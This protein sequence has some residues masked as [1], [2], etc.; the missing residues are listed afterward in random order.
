MRDSGTN[1]RLSD[2][3]PVIYRADYYPF[4]PN[5]RVSPRRS[6]VHT[7]LYI[8]NGTGTITIGQNHYSCAG[9]ELF[10]IPPGVSHT[11]HANPSDPM[12]HASVYFDWTG[13]RSHPGDMSLFSFKGDELSQS[14]CST[15]IIF[16]GGPQLPAKVHAPHYTRWM[17]SFLYIID[18]MDQQDEETLLDRRASFELFAAGLAQ[19]IRQPLPVR[20]QR[21][22]KIMAQMENSPMSNLSVREWADQVGVSTSFLHRLFVQVTGM[23]PHAYALQCKLE[24]ARKRIRE[25]ND[26]IS[27]VAEELGFGS[28]HYFSRL[29]RARFGESPTAYRHRIRNRY[30]QD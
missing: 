16:Q 15:S 20:D 14:E 27:A 18:T 19:A 25:T 8:V 23:G 11:F 5:E 4:H 10:Y 29:F 3:C 30:I 24:R 9:D 22:L 21:V 17:Q 12:T 13:S 1:I 26:L 7:F 6:F 2:I 28:I